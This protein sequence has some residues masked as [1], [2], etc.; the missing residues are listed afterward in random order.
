MRSAMV[1]LPET[2][3]TEANRAGLCDMH[4]AAQDHLKSDEVRLNLRLQ[5]QNRLRY[6]YF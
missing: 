3:L 4:F 2:L 5:L 6:E 1:F